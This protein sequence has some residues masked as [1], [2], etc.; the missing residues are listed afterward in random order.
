[1]VRQDCAAAGDFALCMRVKMGGAAVDL[2]KDD[3]GFD[4]NVQA[5]TAKC[6]IYAPASLFDRR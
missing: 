3:G 4:T 5:S 6:L 2:C 1:M